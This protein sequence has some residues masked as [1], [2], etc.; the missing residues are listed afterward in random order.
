MALGPAPPVPGGFEDKTRLL[1]WSSPSAMWIFGCLCFRGMKG[2]PCSRVD[3]QPE[4]DTVGLAFTEL[5]PRSK[6]S[7]QGR[8]GHLRCSNPS[9]KWVLV[10]CQCLVVGS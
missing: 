10:E 7:N 4:D 9:Q 6:V 5:A 2:F 8:Q 3:R 1:A